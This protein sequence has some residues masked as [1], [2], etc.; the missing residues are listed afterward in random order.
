MV[1]V[2]VMVATGVSCAAP[3]ANP[4]PRGVD[5]VYKVPTGIIPVAVVAGSTVNPT[6]EQ[7]AAVIGLIFAIGCT[8]TNKEKVVPVQDPE[9]GVTW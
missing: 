1:K 3:P 7:V 6:P 8:F 9:T 2:P 5:H 4:I